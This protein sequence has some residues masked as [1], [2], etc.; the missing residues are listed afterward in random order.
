MPDI[1]IRPAIPTDAAD[2][3]DLCGQLGYPS[4]TIEVARRLRQIQTWQGHAMFVAE[5][6]GR[7]VGWV[8]VHAYP[9]PEMDW[10]AE[11]G[12]L[13]VDEG[14][15]GQGIGKLLMARVEGWAQEQGC[16]EIRIRSNVIR[17]RAHDFYQ[18]IGYENTKTQFTF[19]KRIDHGR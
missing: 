15:R 8:H 10:H 6:N 11:L 1:L 13:V 17:E 3:A 19:R 12:G 16:G 7:V 18:K 4:T 9:L 2:I 14:Y 5:N